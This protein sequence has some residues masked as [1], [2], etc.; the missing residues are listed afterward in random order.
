M[1]ILYVTLF[2]TFFLLPTELFSNA[3]LNETSP[4][5][6]QHATNPVEWMPW[7]NE[8]FERAK[9]EDKPIYLSIGYST[10]H[11]CHV[12]EEESFK[13]K[14][15]AAL[16][17]KYFICIKVDREELPQIDSKYQRLYKEVKKH[18]GGWPLNIFM[19]PKKEVYFITNYISPFR[20]SYAEG[21][22]TLLPKLYKIYKDKHILQRE[23]LI[24]NKVKKEK[25]KSNSRLLSIESL[26]I[27]LQKEYDKEFY[28]FGKSKQFPEASKINLMLD[29]ALLLDDKNLENDLFLMLDRMA[30]GGLYDHVGGG[31]FRYSTDLEWEIP[32]FE[33]MLYT[34]AELVSLY[35]RAYHLTHKNLYKDV[36]IESITMLSHKFEKQNLYYSASDADSLG[37]E[38]GYFTFTQQEIQKALKNNPHAREIQEAME[39]SYEGNFHNKVHI[40]F[41][42]EKR[43]KGFLKFRKAL[44]KIQSKRVY[45]FIDKKI[46]TAWNAMMIESLYKASSLDKKYAKKAKEHLEALR[47]MIF[48]HGELYHQGI[49]GKRV[50]QKALLE[51][52]AFF[53]G[54][55]IAA[56]E[57]DLDQG[58]LE[59]AN[60]LLNQAKVKFYK[61]DIWYLSDDGLQ[62]KAGLNDKYYTSAISKML[63]NITNLAA[64]EANF[65]YEK[66]VKKS[67]NYYKSELIS[68][69][70]YVPA[71]AQVYLMNLYG[72]IVLKSNKQN[73]LKEE[74]LIKQI[75]YPY[76]LVKSNND[77]GFM[78]CTL[79]QCFTKE[80]E[81]QNLIE[82]IENH[83]KNR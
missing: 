54:A 44:Q 16:L 14:K 72:V 81:I 51:D 79:R 42:G 30:L 50:K 8:A 60:Y 53:I 66:F 62:I 12:M 23:L 20:D 19:T 29:I 77:S 9:K 2:L 35:L 64:L 33:K 41:Y 55:L 39:F 6:L 38:G 25:K 67:L 28:G 3:L 21:F 52:Y 1:N 32:H 48:F 40:N 34:Q 65:N 75:N 74:Y 58:H 11:W 61:N 7:S 15:I 45:P 18:L 83:K 46:N 37:V 59:F 73:L 68:K 63:Q 78:A 80:V 17:N 31:F 5:L 57:S 70:S 13:N 26:K 56:Y 36:V 27:S 71:L 22:D 10:C 47:E 24:L 49:F 69:Q 43:P 4:Y 76:L 82:Q